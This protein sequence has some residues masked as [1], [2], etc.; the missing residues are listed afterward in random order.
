MYVI[1]ADVTFLVGRK[2]LEKW[3][4]ILNTRRNV[5][6]TDIKGDKNDYKMVTTRTSHY[7]VM[8]EIPKESRV[9]QGLD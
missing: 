8:L 1:E 4:S 5:L 3:G 2:T 7:V 6:E 9:G